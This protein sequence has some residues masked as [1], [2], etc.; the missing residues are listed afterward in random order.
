ME[1]MKGLLQPKRGRCG[2]IQRWCKVLS[3]S[4]N[5]LKANLSQTK[6]PLVGRPRLSFPAS[7]S[8]CCANS[9]HAMHPAL[10]LRGHAFDCCQRKDIKKGRAHN[11]LNKLLYRKWKI[12]CATT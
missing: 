10:G 3:A 6:W 12:L 2:Q 5:N 1:N 11:D 7:R 4:G 8:L 9:P